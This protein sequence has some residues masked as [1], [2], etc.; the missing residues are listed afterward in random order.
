VKKTKTPM[1]EWEGY[2]NV[3]KRE[4]REFDYERG[5]RA[6]D[7]IWLGDGDLTDIESENS[8]AEFMRGYRD[9]RDAIEKYQGGDVADGCETDAVLDF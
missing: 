9:Q 3:T 5:V 4:G 1:I 2:K 7:D 6:T 8:N